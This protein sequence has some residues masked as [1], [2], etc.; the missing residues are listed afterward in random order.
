MKKHKKNTNDNI[1]EEA[2]SLASKD[3]DNIVHALSIIG[4]ALMDALSYMSRYRF[5]KTGKPTE[6]LCART[7]F[8]K[9]KTVH[10]GFPSLQEI[11]K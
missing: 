8:S 10:L 2:I 11:Q 5:R 9:I 4:I 7:I 6:P 3:P 1:I